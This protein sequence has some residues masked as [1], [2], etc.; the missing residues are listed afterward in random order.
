[1]E[2]T[3]TDPEAGRLG[4]WLEEALPGERLLGVRRLAGGNS[5]ETYL[6]ETTARRA[7]L[8][9]PPRAAIAPSAHSMAREHAMLVALAR[10]DVPAP[11]PLALCADPAVIGAPFLLM[12]HVAGESV[13]DRL[14]PGVDPVLAVGQIGPALMDVLALLHGAPWREIGLG[15]FGR[16]DGFLERQVDRWRGQYE[17][18][19]ARDLPRFEEVG[20]W[21]EA[22][23][24]P[25][26]APAILHGD[27]HL[28]NCLVDPA[29]PVR[30]RAIIDWEMATIGD[31][32][33][34]LGLVLAFWGPER[35]A[36]PAFPRIQAVSRVA[37]APTREAL[38][39]RYAE[40]SGRSV[41]ALPYY[42]ALAFWKLA[43]IVEG[44]Y[45]QYLAG[46]LDTPYAR[47][48]ERDVPRLLDEAARFAG[49]A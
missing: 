28:D 27:F 18:Y 23:R 12:E 2:T 20:A 13:L 19:R 35:P 45:A 25:D 6:L 16:P 41:E 8:R 24:P 1:M 48:L 10:T 37:G 4:A 43:A 36:E 39:A 11:R 9:R 30:V 34:D 42:L 3:A 40:R 5:N 44:A 31:P 49:I 46:S 21:L 17:R 47:D 14:P 26:G 15:D 33:L 38:A 7:I 29:P 22:N 32:L